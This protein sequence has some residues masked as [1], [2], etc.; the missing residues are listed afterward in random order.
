MVIQKQTLIQ[1]AAGI[2]EKCGE[3]ANNRYSNLSKRYQVFDL[4]GPGEARTEQTDCGI[5]SATPQCPI[6]LGA[7]ESCT[8]VELLTLCLEILNPWGPRLF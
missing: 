7:L 2:S 8:F 6:S 4:G 1:A 5:R 3:Y